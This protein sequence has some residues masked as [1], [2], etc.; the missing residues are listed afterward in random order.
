MSGQHQLVDLALEVAHLRQV[1]HDDEVEL[2]AARCMR[3]YQLMG[4]QLMTLPAWRAR[5]REL[6]LSARN[7]AVVA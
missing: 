7:Q 5:V 6:L 3:A 4:G 1:V 2:A